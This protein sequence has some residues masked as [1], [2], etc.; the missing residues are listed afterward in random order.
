MPFLSRGAYSPSTK[1]WLCRREP[2]SDILSLV[3]A[4]R[5]VICHYNLPAAPLGPVPSWK[6]GQGFCL[7]LLEVFQDHGHLG[8]NLWFHFS[9]Q[10]CTL[11]HASTHGYGLPRHTGPALA[12]RGRHTERQYSTSGFSPDL[13]VAF[14]PCLPL[15]L[16]RLTNWSQETA[17]SG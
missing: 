5:P 10:V 1:E 11:D 15:P 9:P 13:G 14:L 8:A 6:K 7:T 4:R 16:P 17:A 3:A 2:G 12:K